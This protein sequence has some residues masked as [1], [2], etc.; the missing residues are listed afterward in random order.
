MWE[1]VQRPWGTSMLV[2]VHISA[3]GTGVYTRAHKCTW[4]QRQAQANTLPRRV[5]LESDLN[6]QT[7]CQDPQVP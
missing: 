5:Q 7:R 6:E 2:H 4:T 3:H 1:P